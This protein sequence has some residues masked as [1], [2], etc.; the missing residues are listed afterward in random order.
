MHCENSLTFSLN[1]ETAFQARRSAGG[2]LR[3]KLYVVSVITIPTNISKQMQ[4]RE[5]ER[6]REHKLMTT[7][8]RKTLNTI[9]WETGWEVWSIKQ[10]CQETK[11]QNQ[12]ASHLSHSMNEKIRQNHCFTNREFLVC[13]S[14]IS[15]YTS[16]YISIQSSMTIHSRL[17]PVR[18][19][20][21][22]R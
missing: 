4:E 14:I 19:D 11:W 18:I 21:P 15:L 5:R 6:K 1:C 3:Q 20:F 9:V 13:I 22:R 7:L 2:C 10:N 16:L 12:S 8:P 17:E